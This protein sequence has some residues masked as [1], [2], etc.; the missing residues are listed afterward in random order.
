MKTLL[1]KQL[2]RRG[3]AIAVVLSLAVVIIIFGTA[4]IK[5]YTASTPV[6]K[7]QLDRVQA[8]FF[9]KGI[10]NIAMLKIKKYPSFFLRS[11]KQF[12]YANRAAA[13]GLP[14]L[15]AEQSEPP[16]PF[17]SFME[18]DSATQSNVGSVFC[19]KLDNDFIAPLSVASYSTSIALLSSKDFASS[20]LEISVSVQLKDKNGKGK[21]VNTYKI[22][23]AASK[24]Q[25]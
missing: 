14:P 16:C 2:N 25:I 20:T 22:S 24:I 10:Q 23:A 4:Y 7:L 17:L 21:A 9:A 5:T 18:Y 6:S 15:S 3:M 1:N 11:Y 12:I 13:E 19:C 8:D